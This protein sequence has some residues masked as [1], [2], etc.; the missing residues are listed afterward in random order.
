M[1]SQVVEGTYVQKVVIS[2]VTRRTGEGG[3]VLLRAVEGTSNVQK[4]V[5]SA[6]ARRTGEGGAP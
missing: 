3:V 5:I 4:L 2:A 1:L 6:A